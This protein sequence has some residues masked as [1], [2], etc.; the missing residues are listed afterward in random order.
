MKPDVED[1]KVKALTAFI[2]AL[3][4]SGNIRRD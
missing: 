2:V 4:C 3:V 1:F